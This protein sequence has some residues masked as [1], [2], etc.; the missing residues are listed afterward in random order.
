MNVFAVATQRANP[1][2]IP[3]RD[4]TDD[5][6]LYDL[7]RKHDGAPDAVI[8]D[9]AAN[10]HRIRQVREG[11]PESG[12]HVVFAVGEVL[13]ADDFAREIKH[14]VTD[15]LNCCHMRSLPSRWRGD[16]AHL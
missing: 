9:S 8:R 7:A 16:L 6:V 10:V 3:F 4:V 14:E 2:S 12:Q 13:T 1:L 5:A 15:G 11:L